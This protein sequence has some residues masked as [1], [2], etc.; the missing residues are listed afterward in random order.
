M[1]ALLVLVATVI[2][3][4]F[5]V[6]ADDYEPRTDPNI[7][8][9]VDTWVPNPMHDPRMPERHGSRTCYAIDSRNIAYKAFGR[10]QRRACRAA[11]EFCRQE[12]R[13][14]RS[15]ELYSY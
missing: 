15:C 8:I 5:S 10:D 4:P 7:Q 9:K 12:S 2:T 13:R 1:K 11:I 3:F 6:L 14:P